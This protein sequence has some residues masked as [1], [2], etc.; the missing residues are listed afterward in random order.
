MA[1]LVIMILMKT[2]TL[3][4]SSLALLAPLLL[5]SCSSDTPDAGDSGSSGDSGSETDA[6]EGASA[7]EAAD[8][9][10]RETS[11]AGGP[12]PRLA[13]THE[14]GVAVVDGATLEVLEDFPAEG[15]LRVSPAGDGRHFFLTEGE[16]F[17]LLDG[18]TWGEPHGDH[19]HYYATDPFLSDITV[20]GDTPGHV[21]GH[22]GRGALFFDGSGE[23]AEFDLTDLDVTGELETESASTDE[24]HH[25]V[26]VPLDDGGRV[27]TL[28]DSETRSGA[29]VLDGEGEEVARNEDCPGIHGET[30]G[31]DGTVAF[32][33]EDGV[34]IWDGDEFTT[35]K[36]DEDYARSGNLFAH[37]DSGVLLG[38]YNE[39]PDSEEPM[40]S[41]ALFDVE[42]EEMTTVDVGSAY[43]FRSLARGPEGEAL[44]LAEDGIL[45]VYDADSGETLDEIEV[46]ESWTEPEEWQEPRPAIRVVDDIAYITDPSEQEL[47]MV[48]LVEGEVVNSAE[49]DIEPNELAV[50]DGR[51]VEGVTPEQDDDDHDHEDGSDDHDHD[52]HDHDEE[53]DDH[54]H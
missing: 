19:N 7:S 27:E 32:G 10:D 35:I 47:H 31:P 40:T 1:K 52:G 11:E 29:R 38:D 18:G 24:A 28:G 50:V 15:F 9:S 22:D 2:H 43:N 5:A 12:A 25:G 36:A 30:G 51:P 13:V 21:V 41:V 49:L 34:L 17:R 26:A 39:D 48:D 37:P 45:H 6:P 33:C 8:P 23:I 3:S 53:H 44:V 42:G 16:T 14:G 54:D 46:L 4:W 20:E